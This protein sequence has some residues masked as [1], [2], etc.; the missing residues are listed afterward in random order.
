MGDILATATFSTPIDERY[1]EDYQAGAIFEFG[2]VEVDEAEIIAFSRRFDPQTMHIDPVQAANGR[3]QGLIAS[4]W[5]TVALMMRL[6]VDNYL[7]AVASH[8]SPGVDEVRWFQ[9]VR[10]GDRLRLRVSILEV[11]LSR[12]RPDRGVVISLLQAINQNDIMVSSF[13]AVNL[14]ETRGSQFPKPAS[15][16]HGS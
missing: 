5:H 14:L 12:T 15:V 6:F 7:S 4:G 1:L 8:A 16:L 3:Y 13:K 2:P 11:R 9:P 10:P